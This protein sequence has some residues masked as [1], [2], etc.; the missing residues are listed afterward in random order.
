VQF[1]AL[2]WPTCTRAAALVLERHHASI[3]EFERTHIDLRHDAMQGAPLEERA[4]GECGRRSP[5][6][7]GER[8]REVQVRRRG[9][10]MSDALAALSAEP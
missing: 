7:K 5:R 10:S 3:S 6:G 9:S 4:R 2:T 1:L 8:G